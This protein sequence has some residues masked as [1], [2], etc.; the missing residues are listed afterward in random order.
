MKIT[1]SDKEKEADVSVLPT[2]TPISESTDMM[3]FTS[4]YL[5]LF[6]YV[7]IKAGNMVMVIFVT[8]AA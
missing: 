8:V 5:V 2:W 1:Q 6:K 7:I 3:L 4:V